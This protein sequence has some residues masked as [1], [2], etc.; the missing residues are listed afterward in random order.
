VGLGKESGGVT[1][2]GPVKANSGVRSGVAAAEKMLEG[3]DQ[4]MTNRVYLHYMI[5]IVIVVVVVIII[6]S[7][8]NVVSLRICE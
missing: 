6:L 8:T 1:P 2:S 5:M 3:D 4:Q 7:K